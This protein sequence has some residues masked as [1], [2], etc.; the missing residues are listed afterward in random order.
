MALLTSLIKE[1][2]PYQWL[3][4]FPSQETAQLHINLTQLRGA[5]LYNSGERPEFLTSANGPLDDGGLDIQS[6]HVLQ[7]CESELIGGL[8]LSPLNQAMPTRESQVGG[9]LFA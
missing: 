6:Y 5:I 7:L 3:V 2:H 8:R 4:V 9:I 1:Q